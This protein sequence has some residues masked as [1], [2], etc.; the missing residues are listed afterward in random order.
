MKYIT[1][2]IYYPNA[3]AHIG[4]AYTTILCDALARYERLFGEEVKFL[5][6][7]DEHGQKIQESAE[8]NGV[9]PQEWVDRMTVDFKK[10][11]KD[12]KISNDDFIRTTEQRHIDT[13]QKILQKVYDNGDIYLGEYK[14]KYCVS[15]ET[16]V[17]ESQ[18]V[19]GKYMGKEVIEV[20][21]PSYLSLIHI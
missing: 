17:T 9:S 19:D 20:S 15:E 10:L 16:F 12:L 13:V 11:W 14:G 4:T 7:L 1:T 6:G 5:T 21:E 2:P 18:L 3:K 8:K